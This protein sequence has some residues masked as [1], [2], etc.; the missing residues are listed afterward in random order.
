[1]ALIRKIALWMLLAASA[2]VLAMAVLEL[3]DYQQRAY[4]PL[5]D[6]SL[7]PADRAHI[8][9][10]RMDLLTRRVGDMQ[11]PVCDR[12]CRVLLFQRHQ[13]CPAGGPYHRAHSR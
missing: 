5:R 11:L 3:W 13:F 8:L 10:E 6:P 2:A 4:A 1:M 7:T 9:Q 12:L